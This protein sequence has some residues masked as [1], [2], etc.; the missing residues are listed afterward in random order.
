[1]ITVANS[2]APIDCTRPLIWR[3]S[4]VDCLNPTISL[5]LRSTEHRVSTSLPAELNCRIITPFRS[6][7]ALVQVSRAETGARRSAGY[8]GSLG[9]YLDIPEFAVTQLSDRTVTS[10]T[11]IRVIGS[12]TVGRLRV[13]FVLDI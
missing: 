13:T 7:E 6:N 4:T 5:Y 9:R 11:Y 1:M 2:S 10:P 12:Y 8:L 3:P